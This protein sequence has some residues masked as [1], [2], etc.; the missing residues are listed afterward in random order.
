M[1]CLQLPYIV[2]WI[3]V[4]ELFKQVAPVVKADVYESADGRSKGCGIVEFQNPIDA[5][6]AIAMF[7]R[8]EWHGRRIEVREDRPRSTTGLPAKGPGGS[9]GGIGGS[10]GGN[11]AAGPVGGYGQRATMG[12]FYP[13]TA[14]GAMGSMNAQ[15]LYAQQLLQYQQT[16]QQYMAAQMGYYNN[17]ASGGD[18]PLP[19]GMAGG[20]QGSQGIQQ[21][22]QQ[23][24]MMSNPAIGVQAMGMPGFYGGGV[25]AVG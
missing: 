10:S 18:I 14:G 23:G 21:G 22:I 16:Q 4:K 25:A 9:G 6:N 13:Q 19:M 20:M 8:Y 12:A 15:D 24:M 7:D 3:D 2:T 11:Y 5:R 1:P 17:A